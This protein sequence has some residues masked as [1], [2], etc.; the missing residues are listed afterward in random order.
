M[1]YVAVRFAH[2]PHT[3]NLHEVVERGHT[4]L[5][6]LVAWIVE[7]ANAILESFLGSST[8]L[9][10]WS[11]EE[12]V[13]NINYYFE[14]N[15]D[16]KREVERLREIC[17]GD[18]ESCMYPDKATWVR[19]LLLHAIADYAR[20]LGYRVYEIEAEF[21]HWEVWGSKHYLPIIEIKP[22]LLL[23]FDF[24]P[25]DE[26]RPVFHAIII[27]TDIPM[28][29]ALK[30]IRRAIEL[31]AEKAHENDELREGRAELILYPETG[32]VEI[33]ALP[34]EAVPA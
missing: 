7:I 24:S 29:Y 8:T 10:F 14:T 18:I 6:G 1:A 16:V 27:E 5:V 22:G 33:V 2:F 34:E 9:R 17:G 28:P 19:D 12:T 30:Y 4:P 32:R 11:P 31:L 23:T 15:F 3:W 21:R 13:E 20:K 25:H 26:E